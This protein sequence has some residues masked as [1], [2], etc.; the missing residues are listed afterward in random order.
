LV[1]SLKD[2]LNPFILF[3]Q[4]VRT[5]L[6][7][8]SDQVAKEQRIQDASQA[9][10]HY[11]EVLRSRAKSIVRYEQRLAALKAEF[12]A[13]MQEQFRIFRAEEAGKDDTWT[14]EN[15]KGPNRKMDPRAIDAALKILPEN[16][17]ASMDLFS[18]NPFPKISEKD[19]M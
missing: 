12:E 8:V 1:K 10:A 5:A 3:Q 6:T 17:T 11:S 9:V 19:V 13:E 7:E 2:A 14:V 4:A 16:L 18:G 15:K